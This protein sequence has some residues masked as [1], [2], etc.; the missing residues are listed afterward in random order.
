MNS[1]FFLSGIDAKSLFVSSS[2]ICPKEMFNLTDPTCH[3]QIPYQ[4][5]S[6]YQMITSTILTIRFAF[7]HDTM[8]GHWYFD[9]ISVVQDANVELIINGGFEMNLTGWN[10]NMSSNSSSEMYIDTTAGLAHTGS[11]YFNGDSK[12]TPVYIEQTFNVTIDEYVHISFWWGYDGGLKV[13]DTCQAIGQL[14]S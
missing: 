11:A 12:N 13:G 10:V 14:I 4:Y 9:D 3:G 8:S 5:Y 6:C 2:T 7:Q 1:F